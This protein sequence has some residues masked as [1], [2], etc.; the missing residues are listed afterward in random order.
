VNEKARIDSGARTPIKL[1]L[2]LQDLEFG[3]TQRYA[4]HLLRNLN[5]DL[6]APELWMLRGGLDMVPMAEQCGAELLWMSR[7]SWVPPR[8]LARLAWNLVRRRPQILY[9]LTVVPNIWGRVFGRMARVPAVVASWRSLYPKQ[10]ESLLWP[11]STRIICNAEVLKGVMVDRH[12]VDPQ[13]IA[14]IPNPVDPEVFSPDH[15]E[16]TAEPSVVYVGRL[17]EEK[18]PLTLVEGFRLTAERVP[19]A[20][21]RIVGDGYLEKKVRAAIRRH[22]PESRI[23]MVPGQADIRPELRKA[24]VFVMS[25]S[26]EASPNVILEAMASELPVVASRVGGIPELVREGETGLLFE[27][28]NPKALADSLTGLLL[29]GQQRRLMGMKGRDRVIECHSMRRMIDDTEKVFIEAFNE[30]ARK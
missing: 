5:R 29:D 10:H 27:P 1:V 21:F 8:A 4:I 2:L 28:G 26:C 25:S 13:R 9:T 3:G 15:G 12:G 6:F 23:E 20:K 17:V 30:S 14:V 11:L 7:S 19:Q 16:K 18:D 22:S 24:W